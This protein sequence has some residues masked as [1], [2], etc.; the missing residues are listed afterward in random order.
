MAKYNRCYGGYKTILRLRS[1]KV[2][3]KRD[4]STRP[5]KIEIG[6]A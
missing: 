2:F 1:Q 6:Q 3:K 5:Q 4:A